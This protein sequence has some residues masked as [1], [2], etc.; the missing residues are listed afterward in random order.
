M[1]EQLHSA[2]EFGNCAID[3]LPKHAMRQA[4]HI[5]DPPLGIDRDQAVAGMTLAVLKAHLHEPELLILGFPHQRLLDLA[6]R[7]N[8][9]REDLRA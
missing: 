8:G 2:F 6:R 3:P 4:A 1:I 9:E 5:C 7:D